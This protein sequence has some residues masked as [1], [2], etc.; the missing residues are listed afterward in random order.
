MS[1][2]LLS[3]PETDLSGKHLLRQQRSIRAAG[4]AILLLFH[5]RDVDRL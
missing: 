1:P 3:G 5:S 4:L 2:V